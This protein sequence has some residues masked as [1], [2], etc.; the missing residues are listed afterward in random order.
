MLTAADRLQQEVISDNKVIFERLLAHLQQA[1]SEILVASAWF[2]DDV[3]FDVLLSKAKSG[4]QIHLIIA[5]NEENQKLDFDALKA[6][7][8]TVLRVK[9]VGYGMM[10]QKFCVIDRRL[11]LHGS[12]NWSVNAKKNNH[13][14][15]IIT[16]HAETVESL[17]KVF[18]DIKER[19]VRMLN[20]EAVDAPAVNGHEANNAENHSSNTPSN[21][22]TQKPIDP[23]EE[24]RQVLDAM[25]AAETTG[26]DRDAL[27]REGYERAK[28]TNGDAN[29]LGNVLDS[30]YSLFVSAIDLADEKKRRLLTKIEDLK[31]K[32]Q[33]A[34]VQRSELKM[35]TI[36]AD[37]N[38]Q[39]EVL[40]G[41]IENLR[42]KCE[43]LAKSTLE[44]KTVKI[45]E[46]ER[47]IQQHNE[48]INEQERE[49][50]KP[51]IRWFEFVPVVVFCT[52]LF[53]YL[54]LFYSSAAYILLFSEADAIEARMSGIR[55]TPPE[56][57]HP[58]ALNL[59]W[60]KGLSATLLVLLF[61]IVPIGFAASQIFTSVKWVQGV[62][63]ALGLTVVDG[64]IA[65]KVAKAIH[66]ISYRTGEVDH[67][68]EF[69][70]L[71]YNMDFW[72]VFVMGAMGLLLFKFA[73]AKFTSLMEERNP[74]IHH[75]KSK[76][77]IKQLKADIEELRTRMSEYQTTSQALTSDTVAT[78][79][80][81]EMY[82]KELLETNTEQAT[83]M[84]KC[85]LEVNAKLTSIE[86]IAGIYA[87]HVENENIPIHVDALKDR[88][89]VYLEG[90]N[91]LLHSEYSVSRA[92]EKSLQ[93]KNTVENWQNK[94]LVS[95]KIDHRIS[96]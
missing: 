82:K 35:Q 32:A 36:T 10:H 30:I 58:E 21:G 43:E 11:A 64:F 81:S 16:N 13:E 17:V 93:A 28:S 85:K 18:T 66:D 69:A 92:I 4:V 45:P 71:P 3:L 54:F 48:E 14:S 65:A 73:F 12:Y 60:D 56:V 53:L 49:F 57:F 5:D 84:E 59:V 31:H 46:C 63:L 55:P 2:T 34:C 42:S 68:F 52:V 44:L 23:A 70:S 72:L 79:Q 51:A 20:G 78:E 75:Q 9:N 62:F 40:K 87:S 95:G 24:F 90:W 38:T 47:K 6:Y 77:K 67:P 91:D 33:Q 89:N 83:A 19:A 1:N 80:Q 22:V 37:F 88:I 96:V 29:V 86:R 39:R 41:K 94:K 7:G 27:R 26:F 61:T 25:L 15:I 76:V 8:V 74:D 50:T